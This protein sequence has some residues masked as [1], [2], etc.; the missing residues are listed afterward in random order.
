MDV[1]VRRL[2]PML[3]RAQFLLSSNPK[4]LPLS[5]RPP[6]SKLLRP[7]M[8]LRVSILLRLSVL[9]RLS[10]LLPVFVRELARR[11]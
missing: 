7:S 9:L 11:T 10:I 5:M 8:L 2:E 1:A 4:R 3:L 6:L